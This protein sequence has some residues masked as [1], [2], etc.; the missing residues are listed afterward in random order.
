M[1]QEG[2]VSHMTKSCTKKILSRALIPDGVQGPL[3]A[4]RPSQQLQY[5][6]RLSYT[7]RYMHLSPQ[8]QIPT[9]LI[10]SDSHSEG[11]GRPFWT[12]FLDALDCTDRCLFKKNKVTTIEK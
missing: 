1:W 11:S 3:I 7:T 6:L 9:S 4:L 10:T 12:P 5:N 8:A 2:I